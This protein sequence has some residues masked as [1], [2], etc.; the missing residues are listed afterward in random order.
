MFWQNRNNDFAANDFFDNQDGNP[1][2]RL[3]LNQGGA[4]VG[5]PIKK[6]KLFFYTTYELY[7]LKSQ[8]EA[9]TQILT[10][11]AR[12]GLFKYF[13]TQRN[14]QQV[15]TLNI[16]GLPMDPVM[17]SLLAQVPGP[18]FINNYRTGDSQPGQFM[19]T[20]GYGFLVRDNR[21][22]D[23]AEG[24]LDYYINPKNSVTATYAWNRDRFDRPDIVV[25]Y[26]PIPP[27]QNSDSRNLL[28]VAWRT[29]PSPNWTNEVRVGLNNAPATFGFTSSA[30]GNLPAYFIG[31]TDYS[32][33]EA[34]AGSPIL[35]KTN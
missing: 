32:T 34:L 22:R 24:K 27:F 26:S 13:D 1:L 5:G 30:A 10:A 11:S 2:P 15:N 17:S 16:V 6:D 19:N 20:A 29:N 3:N 8:A 9:E 4:S 28:A 23:N 33:P 25:G 12:Q 18:G 35:S 31:G 21:E 7:R 14:L